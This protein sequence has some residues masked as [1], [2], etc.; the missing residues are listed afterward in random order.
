M[1]AGHRCYADKVTGSKEIRAEP[2]A[3]QVQGCNVCLVAGDWHY[4]I[5]DECE[6]FPNGKYKDQVDAASRAFAG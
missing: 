6:S 1:L 5:L 3:A 4:A 2:L